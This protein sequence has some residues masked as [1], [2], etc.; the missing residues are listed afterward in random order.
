VVKFLILK[1]MTPAKYSLGG[2]VAFAK[3]Q[4]AVL[5]A[6]S[7]F[8][9]V[10]AQEMLL[11]TVDGKQL[12]GVVQRIDPSGQVTGSGLGD[13]LKLDSILSIKTNRPVKEIS[14][15]MQVYLIGETAWGIAKIGAVD[16]AIAKEKVSLAGRL[17]RF[18]LPLQTVRAIVWRDSKTVQQ[19]IAKPSADNDRVI[20]N[21]DGKSQMV[22]GIIEGR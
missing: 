5:L 22:S 13:D 17:G 11:E 3:I 9:A 10:S 16:V 14:Q 20:V 21:V 2:L 7:F 15:P 1:L 4:L 6:S 18:E 12:N 8:G 19:A